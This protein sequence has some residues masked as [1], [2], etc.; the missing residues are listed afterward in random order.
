M[1]KYYFKMDTLVMIGFKLCKNFA[2]RVKT[3]MILT[4]ILQYINPGKKV[5][6]GTNLLENR[7][8][9]NDCLLNN[10]QN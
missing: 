4:G 5:N 3:C 6:H 9:A 7:L 10:L 1:P 8:E 2:G